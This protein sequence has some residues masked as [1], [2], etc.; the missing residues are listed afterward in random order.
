MQRKVIITQRDKELFLY[1]FYNKI[2]SIAQIKEDLFKGISMRAVYQRL[3][4]LQ[5][6]EWIE[7]TPY[8]DEKGR[9]SSHFNV[10]KKCLSHHLKKSIEVEGGSLKSDSILHDLQLNDIRRFFLSKKCI[11]SYFTE[12]ELA[13]NLDLK[14]HLKISSYGFA[15]VDSVVRVK[16]KDGNLCHL[17]VEYEHTFKSKER[18]RQKIKNYYLKPQVEVILF[19][20]KSKGIYNRFSDL[21]TLFSQQYDHPKLFFLDIKEMTSRNNEVVFKNIN[22]DRIPIK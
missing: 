21:E 19:I 7:C 13:T 9:L 2:A 20:Y 5:M 12:N 15:R 14:G 8:K 1:L 6:A 4:K 10:T 22:G 3:R 18:C 17:G 16:A 11:E